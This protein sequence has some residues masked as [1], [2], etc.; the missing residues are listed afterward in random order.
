MPNQKPSVYLDNNATTPVADE[1]FEAMA[2]FFREHFG[3]ASSVHGFGQHAR[4]AVE[5]ARDQVAQSIGASPREIVFT[6]GGTEA[7]NLAVEGVARALA[8]RGRHIITTRIEHHAVLRTCERLAEEGFEVSYLEPDSSG[9]VD[10]EAFRKAVREDTILASIMYVNNE[11]GT[12]QPLGEIT[13]LA[14]ED[15]IL[16]H[17]DAVQ[18]VGKIPVDVNV[19]GLDLL[20]L[21]GHKFHGPKGVG[22]LFVRTGT[23]IEPT[24]LGGG[25]ERGLRGGTENVPGIVG[26]GKACESAASAVERMDTTVRSLRDRLESALLDA[27]P[28][29]KV[30]GKEALRAP[31]VANI[32][33]CGLQ[34]ESILVSL[35]FQG[36][37][38]S[39]GAACASGSISPSHVLLAM[40]MEE[41]RIQSAIRFSLSRLTTE[42][43]IDAAIEAVQGSLSRMQNAGK[44]PVRS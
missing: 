33:F 30:N 36:I 6:C 23:P 27:I 18:A 22:A 17:S 16:V 26:L 4:S 24:M 9:R 20:S 11:T 1:V 29:A 12:V 43:E 2:P 37:A 15:G 10:P 40:G 28:S 44:G 31:H 13:A 34:G 5:N 42:A 19:L 25:Q 21:S 8:D 14:H 35:D 39:T 7:D 41:S 3:N 32:S 38:V